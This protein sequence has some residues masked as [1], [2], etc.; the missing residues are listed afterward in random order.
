VLGGALPAHTQEAIAH[1]D[2]GAQ[3]LT[4]LLGSPEFLRR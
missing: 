4:L 2:S 1:A 3:A